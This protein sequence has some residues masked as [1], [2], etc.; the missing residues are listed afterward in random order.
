MLKDE[1][2]KALGENFAIQWLNLGG[3]GTTTKPDAGKFPE[4]DAELAAAMRAETVSYFHAIFHADR[5]L[6]ELLSSD[7]TYLNERLAKHYGIAG[8][9]GSEMRRVDLKDGNRGGIVTQASV[10]TM[11]SYPLRTSPVLRGRFVLEEILGSKVPPP[12]P[13]VPSL[14]TD[15]ATKDGLTLRQQLEQHRNKAE[16]NGCHSRMDPIGFG[17][18][19]FDPIGRWRADLAGQPIDSTG[20]LPSGEEFKNPAELKKILLK[21]KHETLKHLSRKM[22]GYALG[23]ELNNKFDQCIVDDALKALEANEYRSNVLVERI[24]LSYAF[25]HRYVKK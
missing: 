6:T 24:V 14:P 7:Y 21:R 23:R 2:S 10:L 22:L 13:N 18:E 1:R 11:S 20:K 3:L 8:I 12:P 5:P 19:N 15:D 25:G 16:C 9:S 4:F 17:L